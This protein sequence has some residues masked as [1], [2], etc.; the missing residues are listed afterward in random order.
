MC[1]LPQL[2]APTEATPSLKRLVMAS[3][4][5]AEVS[6]AVVAPEFQEWCER[7][8]VVWNG[9]K[10][11]FVAEGWRGIV[12]TRDLQPGTLHAEAVPWTQACNPC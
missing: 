8:G 2:T 11:A 5:G 3:A 10:A 7:H 1:R 9:I 4:A 12:A 6:E